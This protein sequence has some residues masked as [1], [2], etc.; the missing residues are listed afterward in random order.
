M[1]SAEHS[2]ANFGVSIGTENRLFL[3]LLFWAEVEEKADIII[4]LES[5]AAG[6]FA[7]GA[8]GG[9]ESGAAAGSGLRTGMVLGAGNG[10]READFSTDGTDVNPVSATLAPRSALLE[11]HLRAWGNTG[12]DG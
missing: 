9:L 12:G 8:A 7:S 11:T 5:G 1:S 4:G 10:G 6:R 2:G 3:I